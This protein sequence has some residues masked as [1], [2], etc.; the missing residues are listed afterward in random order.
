MDLDV[1]AIHS[2]DVNAS[3]QA[4]KSCQEISPMNHKFSDLHCLAYNIGG[5]Q[6]SDSVVLHKSRPQV[7]DVFSMMGRSKTDRHQNEL[8]GGNCNSRVGYAIFSNVPTPDDELRKASAISSQVTTIFAAFPP[9][10]LG[11]LCIPP[12]EH[13]VGISPYNEVNKELSFQSTFANKLLTEIE[14]KDFKSTSSVWGLATLTCDFANGGDDIIANCCDRVSVSLLDSINGWDV[15]RFLKSEQMHQKSDERRHYLIFTSSKS[16]SFK[17]EIGVSNQS[18]MVSVKIKESN[19]NRKS[20]RH[21]KESIQMELRNIHRCE[22]GWFCNRCLQSSRYGSFSNCASTCGK[23]AVAAIC[24]GENTKSS[25]VKIDVEVT[26]LARPRTTS[27]ESLSPHAA[28]Q[29]RIPRIIHQ[30]YFEQIDMEK[31]PQLL[32]LQNT[33]KASGWQY[34]FYTDDTARHFIETNYP[35]RFASVFDALLP[36]A[37]KVETLLGCILS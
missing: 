9:N 4:I 7:D 21:H 28:R 1:I 18:N 8:G 35:P 10:H 36:G 3:S 13:S 5:M 22:P 25:R 11:Y 26:G 6:M 15:S 31:Y 30:T 34:R 16:I 20:T 12:F 29:N 24:S 17:D 19:N 14:S 37:Y 27:G 2:S 32:R 23:C 33:W